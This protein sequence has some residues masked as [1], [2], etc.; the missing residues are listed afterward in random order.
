MTKTQQWR[1]TVVTVLI[2][3]AGHMNCQ[4]VESAFRPKGKHV[5]IVGSAVRGSE[6]LALAKDK[7]PDVAVISAQLDDGG[8]EGYRLLREL[9]VVSARTRGIMLLHSANRKW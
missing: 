7:Q 3:Q 8:L 2:A 1:S 5:V 6:A 4:L 9:R